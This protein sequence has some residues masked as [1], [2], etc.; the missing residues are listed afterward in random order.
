MVLLIGPDNKQVGVFSPEKARQIAEEEYNLELVEV[1]P[2]VMKIMDKAKLDYKKSKIKQPKPK[3]L[4]EIKFKLNIGQADF[5]TKCSH[6]RQFL[7]KGNQ[8]RVTIWFSGREVSRPDAGVTL[9]DRVLDSVEEYGE[10]ASRSETLQNKN[11]YLTLQ[12]R[13]L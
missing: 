10:V 5:D 6:I 7:V 13:R 2:N 1:Q 12:P 4:K 11:L 8:V 3:P 9:L